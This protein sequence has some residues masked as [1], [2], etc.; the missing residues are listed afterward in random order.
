MSEQLL[1]FFFPHEGAFPASAG[2]FPADGRASRAPAVLCLLLTLVLSVAARLLELPFWDNPS[3]F[4]GD[5]RLLATHDAYHWLAGAEGFEFGAGHPMSELARIL[6]EQSCVAPAR[7]A[8]YLPPFMSAL[9]ALGV[10]LWCAGFGRPYA[11]LCAGV[12]CSLSP[13]FCARTMLGFYDTDLVIL[14][15]A[16][17]LGLI[18][19][20]WLC[21]L[22]KSPL[23]ALRPRLFH[24][25]R[26]GEGNAAGVCP[27]RPAG[28]TAGGET[29]RLRTVWLW[30]LLLSGLLGF[31]MQEWHSLFPYLARYY[32]LILP[33]LILSLGPEKEK[34]ELLAFALCH[35]LPLLLG[36]LAGLLPALACALILHFAPRTDQSGPDGARP[37]RGAGYAVLRLL[38]DKRTLCALWLL[39]LLAALDSTVLDNLLRSFAAYTQ[40]GGDPSPLSAPGDPLI[41]PSVAQSII[42]VQTISFREMLLYVYPFELLTLLAMGVFALRLFTMPVMFWFVPLFV[43]YLLSLHMGARMTMFGAPV[44]MITLCLEGGRIAELVAERA[45]AGRRRLLSALRPGFCLLCVFSLSWPLILY[46]PDYSQGPIF[47]REQAEGLSYLKNNSAEDAVIW[48]WWDWGYAAHHFARRRTIS[49]GA[50]HGGPSLFLPAAVYTTADP[51][52]ARQI[53]KYT[54]SKGNVPGNVFAGISARAAQRLMEDLSDRGKPL[55][56]APGEQYLVVGFELLHLGLWIT[57]YG[58]WNF[59][60]KRAPGALMNNLA[61]ALE[62]NVETGVV[63]SDEAKPIYA[64]TISVFSPAGRELFNFNRYGAYH[65]IFNSKTSV[66]GGDASLDLL[67]DFWT[68]LRGPGIF[69]GVAYDKIVMDDIFYNT[70][71]VQLLIRQPGD[72]FIAPYFKL[73]FDNI[74]TR[75]YKVL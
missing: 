73:V 57:R 11:G 65:F 70:M 58:S 62:Y 33:C 56:E 54:A 41:F 4:L 27:D 10:F 36:P 8:F 9:P 1:N 30:P 23:E 12:L 48:N 45:F 68:C 24:A 37:A 7:I 75:I 34:R 47:S 16:V 38:L 29:A 3:F 20:L 35:A 50:R 51:R 42:E 21:P 49:D 15:F 22:L 5:E 31:R 17:L 55:I 39:V 71:M 67:R 61:P 28:N 72:P 6:S 63:L 66:Y 64:A 46:I 43:L 25:P 18:P 40:R 2:R 32:A 69:S 26:P 19:A 60:T 52:F 14:L 74:Y 44:V 59:E 13:G 53:I